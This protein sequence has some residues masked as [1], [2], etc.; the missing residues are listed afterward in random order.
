MLI[1][2]FIKLQLLA[3]YQILALQWTGVCGYMSDQ[4][5][6]SYKVYIFTNDF[7]LKYSICSWFW[8][9]KNFNGN[10]H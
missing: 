2:T 7:A 1:S 10:I 4:I 5:L 9:K 6:I 8:L 3:G